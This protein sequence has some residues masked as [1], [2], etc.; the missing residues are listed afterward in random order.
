[1]STPSTMSTAAKRQKGPEGRDLKAQ[2]ERSA[3]LGEV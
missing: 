2:G 1:M 3:A